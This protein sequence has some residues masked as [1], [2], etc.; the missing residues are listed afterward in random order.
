M[1]LASVSAQ[2][3]EHTTMDGCGKKVEDGGFPRYVD[4]LA[5]A[6]LADYLEECVVRKVMSRSIGVEIKLHCNACAH[7]SNISQQCLPRLVNGRFSDITVIDQIRVIRS[8][9]AKP[10]HLSVEGYFKDRL[11][12]SEFPLKRAQPNAFLQ[13]ETM[14]ATWE[15]R[16]S[17]FGTFRVH[18]TDDFGPQ[19]TAS[20]VRF[21]IRHGGCDKPIEPIA[22]EFFCIAVLGHFFTLRGDQ[23]NFSIHGRIP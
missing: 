8:G 22:F 7:I 17:E 3:A 4:K 9:Q 20:S 21:E 1:A 18:N 5:S 13:R 12:P 6:H 14:K 11:T 16:I 10:F 2:N 19:G 23:V 15:G